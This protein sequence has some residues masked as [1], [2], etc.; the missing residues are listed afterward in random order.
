MRKKIKLNDLNFFGQDCSSRNQIS[1]KI[2]WDRSGGTADLVFFTDLCLHLAAHPK[3][4]HS[5]KI[6]WILEPKE[7]NPRLYEYVFEHQELFDLV[8]THTESLINLMPE[9]AKWYPNGM[10]HFKKKDWRVYDKTKIISIIAS[11]KNQT[12][13]QKF[14]HEFIKNFKGKIDVYGYGYKKIDDKLEGLQD[15]RFSVAI[16]NSIEDTYFSEKIIDCF[17]T[18]TVPIYWGTSRIKDYFNIDGIFQLNNLYQEERKNKKDDLAFMG[19]IES[20]GYDFFN[21]D[22]VQKAIKYNF[23]AAQNSQFQKIGYTIIF[24]CRKTL[25]DSL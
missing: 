19:Y 7:I 1:E 25:Y 5:Y 4:A 11:G 15:Y 10:C 12:S 23:Y 16:E 18:G 22:H 8:L 14:R 2:E 6:A 20:K 9:K 24:C 3:Y 13:G 21:Y 17:I